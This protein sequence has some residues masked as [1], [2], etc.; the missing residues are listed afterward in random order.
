MLNNTVPCYDHAFNWWKPFT[1]EPYKRSSQQV[2][3]ICAVNPSVCAS[4]VSDSQRTLTCYQEFAAGVSL[5]LRW[6]WRCSVLC[7]S[8]LE[9]F[10]NGGSECSV[11]HWGIT[12]LALLHQGH[13]APLWSP[14]VYVSFLHQALHPFRA[15]RDACVWASVSPY[16]PF[17]QQ[18]EEK[19]VLTLFPPSATAR[20][21]IHPSI[22]W[23]HTLSYP[24]SFQHNQAARQTL[25]VRQLDCQGTP[26][27]SSGLSFKVWV[28]LPVPVFK[29]IAAFLTLTL[30]SFKNVFIIL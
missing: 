29:T 30:W 7:R 13:S 4:D 25:L 20:R 24:H 28:P 16:P 11:W 2:Q 18:R 26:T 10:H 23:V 14:P 15:E 17:G 22:G 27:L 9:S 19:R 8:L 5:L 12:W 1:K 21:S 3:C 6:M